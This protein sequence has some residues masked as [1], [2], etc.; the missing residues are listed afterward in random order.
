LA[1]IIHQLN[2]TG[3]RRHADA[4]EHRRGNTRAFPSRRN[5]AGGNRRQRYKKRERAALFPREPRQAAKPTSNTSG[6][7]KTGSR[8][9]ER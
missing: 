6:S 7:H 8:S 2:E 5:E 4:I 1:A 3:D 9:A